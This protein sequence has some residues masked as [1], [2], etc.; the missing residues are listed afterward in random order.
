VCVVE[1]FGGA[2]EWSGMWTGGVS[3]T[4]FEKGIYGNTVVVIGKYQIIS[5]KIVEYHESNHDT[6]ACIKKENVANQVVENHA[7][8]K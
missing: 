5:D 3:I 1:G 8:L 7:R 6:S 4:L 2:T